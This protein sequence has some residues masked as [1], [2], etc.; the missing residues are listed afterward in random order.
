MRIL[1]TGAT[2]YIG[3]QLV[4]RLLD[5]GHEVH[6]LARDAGTARQAPWGEKV[7]VHEG[8]LLEPETLA[9]AFEGVEVAYYLV[10]S[11]GGEG[12]FSKRDRQAARNVANAVQAAGTLEHVVY[13][14]G[15]LPDTGE[16]SEHLASRAEVGEI[17]REALPATEF[18]AGPIVGAGSGSFEMVRY[19]TERLP[20]MVAPKWIDNQVQPIAVEDVLAYLVEAAERE[21]MG[22]VE[23]GG[24]DRPSFREMMQLYAD[25]RELHRF[26]FRVPVLTP[27][28]A[29]L[30]VG[31]VTPI[32]NSL[33]TPLIEGILS[34]IVADTRRA[35]E[36]F[37]SVEPVGYREAVERALG[38][39]PGAVASA[40]VEPQSTR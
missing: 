21:P 6:V 23:I 30:W 22:V 40:N 36:L 2:G 12:D 4:P 1:V 32:P 9:G 20:V 33:A 24:P 27:H 7:K 31:L 14:G 37:P 5:A 18:R 19:L 3:G 26:I 35:Q 11:M 8:D 28:L 17:L 16:P 13:L 29:S 25:V 39:A 34:P 15:L 38:R 10:H